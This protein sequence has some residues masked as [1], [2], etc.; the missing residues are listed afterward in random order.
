M[1][2]WVPCYG[3]R[4]TACYPHALGGAQD[5]EQRGPDFEHSGK[6]QLPAN[7]K[8]ILQMSGM[9]RCATIFFGRKSA[10]SVNQIA[11]LNDRACSHDDDSARKR[12]S[13]CRVLVY[14]LREIRLVV[15]LKVQNLKSDH[16]DEDLTLLKLVVIIFVSVRCTA[17]SHLHERCAAQQSSVKQSSV[18]CP[19]Q[20]THVFF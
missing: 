6:K 3:G 9:T 4:T 14:K 11:F 15:N 19:F 13:E 8:L 16:C 7:Q 2:A 10:P 12:E 18:Q 20:Q 17:E 1:Q 5:G